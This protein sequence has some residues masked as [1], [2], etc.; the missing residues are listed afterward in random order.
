MITLR[1]GDERSFERRGKQELWRTF[2]AEDAADPLGHGFGAL[3]CL[4]ELRLQPGADTPRRPPVAHES[5]LVTYVREGVLAYEDSLGRSGVIRAGEFQRLTAGRGLRHSQANASRSDSAQVLQLWLRPGSAGRACGQEQKR[6][7][8]A[9][10]RGELCIVASPDARRGSLRLEQ[11]AVLCSS[12]LNPGQHLAHALAPGRSAWLHVVVG[13]V[14][15]GNAV[16]STGDGAGLT[17][18]RAVSLTAREASEILLLDL[19]DPKGS[20]V[21]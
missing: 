13:E 1:R 7:S 11:D 17:A 5:E 9:E 21:G 2:A 20:S 6:F 3:E 16:L 15:L 8:A 4:N 18:E 12:L 10:R 19:D 14:T